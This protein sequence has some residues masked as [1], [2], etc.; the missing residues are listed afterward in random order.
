MDWP[1]SPD[2]CWALA[3]ARGCCFLRDA[4]FWDPSSSPSPS[5]LGLGS[6]CPWCDGH[7]GLWC[8]APWEHPKLWLFLFCFFAFLAANLPLQ[9]LWRK[10]DCAQGAAALP[11]PPHR[12]QSRGAVGRSQTSVPLPS[13]IPLLEP[14]IWGTGPHATL[15]S[16]PMGHRW[17]SR[18]EGQRTGTAQCLCEHVVAWDGAAGDGWGKTRILQNEDKVELSSSPCGGHGPHVCWHPRGRCGGLV[19]LLRLGRTAAWP[20]R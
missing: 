6:V 7:A 1:L 13:Q 11:A 3:R 20:L 5:A 14:A 9:V 15:L 2:G 8:S 17:G 10:Q 4:G 18:A 12:G 16:H 19:W